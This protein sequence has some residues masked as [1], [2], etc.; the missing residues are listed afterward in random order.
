MAGSAQKQMKGRLATNGRVALSRTTL[1]R[2]LYR[3]L[4]NTGRTYAAFRDTDRALVQRLAPAG[5]ILDPM[6]GYGRVAAFCSELGINSVGVEFNPPQYFWQLLCHPQCSDLHL[7]AIAFLIDKRRSWPRPRPRAVV[8]DEFF[9]P[10]CMATLE[11]LLDLALEFYSQKRG[12]PFDF[13]RL[14]LALLMPFVG[15]ISCTSPADVSTHTKQGGTCV[16]LGLQE[17]FSLYLAALQDR[18]ARVRNSHKPSQHDV[19]LGDARTVSFGRKKFRAMLTSPPYPNHRDFTT[20]LLP[21]NEFLFSVARSRGYP[22]PFSRHDIIGSNFVK[23]RQQE[24]VVHSDVAAK[25]IADAQ[26]IRRTVRAKY[27][28][29]TY[30]IPYFSK[31]FSALEAAYKNVARALDVQCEG[32]ITV[33]NNTHRG[34]VIPVSEVVQDIWRGIGFQAEVFESK[35]FSHV[36]AKNPRAKGVRARHTEYVVR[37]WR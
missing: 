28:D 9:P 13:W 26:A 15:R 8:S 34:I 17:D 29:D 37:I 10:E 25:F 5:T 30:Y 35:E 3:S 19:Q 4:L 16:L 14:A 2:E 31:Y 1:I 7:S 20:I 21:E 32:Y 18:L 27:D 24:F 22:I 6:S 23:G 12:L 11:R 36:G 33:V